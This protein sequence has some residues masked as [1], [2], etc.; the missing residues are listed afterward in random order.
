MESPAL[1]LYQAQRT[2]LHHLDPRVKVMLTVLIIFSNILLPDGAWLG[3]IL[4]WTFLLLS[5]QLSRVGIGFLL[6]RSLIVLPFALAAATI[7]IS[8]PGD[9]LWE[10]PWPQV[11]ITTAGLIRFSTI[12]LRSWISVQAAILLSATTPFPDLIHALRHLKLPS[13]LVSTISFMY[14]Y[15]FVLIGEAHRLLRA[16]ASRSAAGPD[17][18]KRSLSWSARTAGSMV[19]QLFLRSVERSERIYQAMQVRG[20]RGQLLTLNPHRMK[21]RDW[22]ILSSV[23][24]FLLL[25]QVLTYFSMA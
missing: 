25:I 7:L 13:V 8:T 24:V 14:R 20:Y 17:G 19:G 18:R 2:P 15:L 10:L 5:A 22:M 12:M 9:P 1:N 6:S 23:T 21:P 3:L 11:T 16:R 4:T